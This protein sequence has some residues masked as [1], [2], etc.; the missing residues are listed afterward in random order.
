LNSPYARLNRDYKIANNFAIV[1][2]ERKSD[3]KLCEKMG[4]STVLSE[5]DRRISQ[6]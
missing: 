6:Y 5:N 4:D 2:G 3:A 1:S